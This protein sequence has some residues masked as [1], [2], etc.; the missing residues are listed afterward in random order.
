MLLCRDQTH[1]K[2]ATWTTYT[3]GPHTS[4]SIRLNKLRC[5]MKFF[6]NFRN[7]E[8][9]KI[10][11][12]FLENCCGMEKP[13]SQLTQVLEEGKGRDRQF[14]AWWVK[15]K[16]HGWFNV[17]FPSLKTKFLI[18]TVWFSEHAGN[19]TR[20]VQS[21]LSTWI[22]SREGKLMLGIA[23]MSVT[24][25]I[26]I[27]DVVLELLWKIFM[28][29]LSLLPLSAADLQYCFSFNECSTSDSCYRKVLVWCVCSHYS[30][31]QWCDFNETEHYYPEL[32][33][34]SIARS[35]VLA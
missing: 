25:C 6:N 24:T 17:F 4:E 26:D 12:P 30:K 22:Q 16:D 7:T 21:W 34:I 29:L 5:C 14:Y 13:L 19:Q 11:L 3:P 27:G 8:L 15:S 18:E 35:L 2:N 23:W 10:L 20:A 33:L 28:W 31:A 1:Y 32:V 9:T